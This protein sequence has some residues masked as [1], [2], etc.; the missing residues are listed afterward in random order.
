MVIKM[1]PLFFRNQVKHVDRGT[2][3]QYCCNSMI[4]SINTDRSKLE[5]LERQCRNE[6]IP[7]TFQRRAILSNLVC[8]TDHPTADQI[9]EP[10][11]KRYPGISRT[12]VYRVL[13]MFVRLGVARKISNPEAKAR[14]DADT[15]SHNHL[16]CLGC[17][18]VQDF[19]VPEPERPSLPPESLGGF[20][21][22]DCSLTVTGYCPVCRAHSGTPHSHRMPMRPESLPHRRQQ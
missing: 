15:C 14:F 4:T 8:R 5:E 12:T 3:L 16:I 18:C 9:F 13:D 6:G 10:L 22:V 2:C 19:V 1:Y 21:V 20:Q 17:G 7:L 11:K